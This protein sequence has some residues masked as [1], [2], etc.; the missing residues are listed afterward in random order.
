M[1][2]RLLH[3][4]A[5]CSASPSVAVQLQQLSSSYT[6]SWFIVAPRAPYRSLSCRWQA[7]ARSATPR[8]LHGTVTSSIPSCTASPCSSFSSSSRTPVLTS[9]SAC[10]SSS[11]D[12]DSA[13][14]LP[15]ILSPTLPSDSP[16]FSIKK[17]LSHKLGYSRY[18]P[19]IRLYAALSQHANSNTFTL[20]TTTAIPACPS[21]AC[22]LLTLHMWLLNSRLRALAHAAW[23]SGR[24]AEAKRLHANI[25]LLFNLTWQEM[26]H[27]LAEEAGDGERQA[28]EGGLPSHYTVNEYQQ[29]SYGAMVSYDRA[30]LHYRQTGQRTDLMGALWR[31]VWTTAVPLHTAHLHALAAYVEQAVQLSNRWTERDITVSGAVQWPVLQVDGQSE[32]SELLRYDSRLYDGSRVSAEESVGVPMRL[33]ESGDDDLLL[34]DTRKSRMRLEG[35]TRKVQQLSSTGSRAIESNGSKKS[36]R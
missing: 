30:W 5:G 26:E 1:R 27:T 25:R 2:S 20:P 31:N 7:A 23:Q 35:E 6:S 28:V 8:P 22:A 36:S 11:A 29:L 9:S 21:T 15:R 10:V 18:R 33:W 4:A 32:A 24:E 14:S 19:I 12:S 13:T 17:W 34:V 3:A 16:S